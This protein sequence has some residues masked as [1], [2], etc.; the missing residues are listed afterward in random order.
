MASANLSVLFQRPRVGLVDTL[1]PDYD[2]AAE[3]QERAYSRGDRQRAERIHV[4]YRP[5][6]VDIGNARRSSELAGREER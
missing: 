4:P 6:A 3:L 1:H 2:F 5:L